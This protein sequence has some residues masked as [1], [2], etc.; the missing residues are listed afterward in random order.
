MKT[1]WKTFI[2][3]ILFFIFAVCLGSFSRTKLN[4]PNTKNKSESVL[5]A[6]VGKDNTEEETRAHKEV[7][8][9]SSR[10]EETYS[11]L[12]EAFKDDR[13]VNVLFVGLEDIRT[14]TIILSS[15]HM[16]NK[17]VDSIFIPRDTYIHR[18]GY[19]K[20]E[21]RKINAIYGSHGISGVK[22]A[23]SYL[24]EDIPIHHHIIMDY[25]G[26]ENIVDTVGGVE[27]VVPFPMVY[28]DTTANPPVHINIPEGRQVLDGKKAMDFLRYRKGNTKKVGYIDGD[29]GRIRA[30]QEFLKS[31]TK[32]A[33]SYRLPFV[34]KRG[35]E[36]IETDIKLV[37][38]L[39]YA[40]KAVGIKAEDF[41]FTTLPGESEFKRIRG[42]LLS[43]FIPNSSETKKLLEELYKVK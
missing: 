36:Y 1:F 16:D 23:V 40:T 41:K 39:N 13:R 27:V 33:L 17:K 11:S 38:A 31:F 26:V 28:T 19:N 35:F 4:S 21:Q 12:E 10:E 3:S 20:G 22:K 15:F 34:V 25:E 42:Q 24:L 5:E 29:L 6:R 2:L 9:K 37:E 30:Q 43:Y 14:D 7:G 18:E 8:E 32:K